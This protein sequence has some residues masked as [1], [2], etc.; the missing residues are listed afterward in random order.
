MCIRG[1]KG[2]IQRRQ[3]TKPYAIFKGW[4]DDIK[5]RPPMALYNIVGGPRHGSTVSARTLKEE[6][7]VVREDLRA[8]LNREVPGWQKMSSLELDVRM[9]R[10]WKAGEFKKLVTA[11]MADSGKAVK[12][13]SG[14]YSYIEV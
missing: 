8:Y 3:M 10:R 11:V 7:I 13:G 6:G 4:Q 5:G 14:Y 1:I 2:K 9:R 12:V